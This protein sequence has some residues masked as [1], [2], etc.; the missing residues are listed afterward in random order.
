MVHTAV[1]YARM[2]NR[3]RA[4]ACTT[5]IGPGATNLVTGAAVATINR[6]P[7]LLVPGDVFA[8]R[9]S[10]PVLQQLED[11]TGLDVSVNDCLRPVS[12]YFDRVWRPEQLASA[13]L[14]ATRVL[15]DPAETGA[16][17]I[18]LP[19]DVATEAFEVPDDLFAPRVWRV[20]AR[21]PNPRDSMKLAAMLAGRTP[22]ARDRGW[23]GSSTRARPRR[24]PDS[25]RPPGSRS[26]RPRP[27]RVPCASTTRRAWAP[28]GRRARRRPTRSRATPTW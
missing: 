18:A 10:N 17:T 28:S 19:Q 14:N 2:S 22:T 20:G 3:L 7:V 9:R 11:P 25:A 21:R 1:G 12:R 5:S 16:V 26:P 27:A 4:F 24:S 13:L 15:T 8:T 6:I 23:R